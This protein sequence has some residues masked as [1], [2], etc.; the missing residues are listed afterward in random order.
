MTRRLRIALLAGAAVW[1]ILL[2][3]GFVAP[4]G[5]RWGVAG[6]V[7]HVWNYVISLW[8][9]VLVLAPILAARAPLER[10]AAIQLFLLGILGIAVSTV[11]AEALG[12]LTDGV[13]L[14]ACALTAGL[15]VWVHPERARL[16]RV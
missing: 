6:P 14:G 5:W 12:W 7:G 4:G 9:V 3:A 16:W 8:L 2:A 10:T 13:P 15:V 1:L 11:R